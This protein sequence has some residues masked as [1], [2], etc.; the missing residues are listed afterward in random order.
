ML[1]FDVPRRSKITM[2]STLKDFCAS[3]Q[4]I[5]VPKV[6]RALG[7]PLQIQKRREIDQLRTAL[8]AKGCTEGNCT[9]ANSYA[10]F[11]ESLK[12]EAFAE[13]TLLCNNN[14]TQCVVC[15]FVAGYFGRLIAIVIERRR[16]LSILLIAYATDQDAYWTRTNL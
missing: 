8:W 7:A 10:P 5:S 13:Q 15:K 4:Q 14:A 1:I 3:K 6:R 16:N 9:A 11:A 2:G 12:N